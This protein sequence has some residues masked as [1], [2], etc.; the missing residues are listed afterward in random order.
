MKTLCKDNIIEMVVVNDRNLE[1]KT[2]KGLTTGDIISVKERVEGYYSGYGITPKF[3][4]TPGIKAVVINPET[5][6]VW[7]KKKGPDTFICVEFFSPITNAIE[8]AGILDRNN[9]IKDK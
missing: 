4:L 2:Y 3:Y 7:V 1:K 9:I 8:R 6:C 5:P